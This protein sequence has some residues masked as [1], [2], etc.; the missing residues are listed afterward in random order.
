MKATKHEV[1]RGERRN[2]GDRSMQSHEWDLLETVTGD[3]QWRGQNQEWWLNSLRSPR[4]PYRLAPSGQ[5][6]I[7]L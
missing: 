7:W 3:K 1:R 4:I 2:R 6:G 5:N